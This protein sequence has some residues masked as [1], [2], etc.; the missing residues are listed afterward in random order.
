MVRAF[1]LPGPILIALGSLSACVPPAP[2]PGPTTVEL[3]NTTSL[4]V[5]P[6]LYV[7]GAATD[8]EELFVGA[9]LVTVYPNRHYPELYSSETVTLTFEHEQIQSLGVKTPALFDA[10]VLDVTRSTDQIF[11]LRGTDFEDATT[12]RF[13][14][15]MDGDTFSVRVET[16]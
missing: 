1:I 13:V 16:P 6:N 11:L 2:A 15:F 7:S 3:V 5:S 12:V 10:L 8:A 9:N 14:Y 4:F